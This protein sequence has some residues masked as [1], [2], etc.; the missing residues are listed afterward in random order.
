MGSK[1]YDRYGVSEDKFNYPAVPIVVDEGVKDVRNY[2]IQG[3]RYL[4]EEL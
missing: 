1:Y 2:V 3:S 4:L